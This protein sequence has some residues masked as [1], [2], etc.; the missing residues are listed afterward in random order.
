MTLEEA[1]T[2]TSDDDA[3]AAAAP[4]DVVVVAGSDHD[5]VTTV[6]KHVASSSL[7]KSIKTTASCRWKMFELILNS[8][9]PI[10]IVIQFISYTTLFLFAMVLISI[11]SKI[12]N[13]QEF[14]FFGYHGTLALGFAVIWIVI[15]GA[16]WSY[17]LPL[18]GGKLYFTVVGSF[19][20]CLSLL[21]HTVVSVISLLVSIKERDDNTYTL[22]YHQGERARTLMSVLIVCVGLYVLLLRS[23][24]GKLIEL[25]QILQFNGTRTKEEAIKQTD[26]NDIE[27]LL[28]ADEIHQLVIDTISALELEYTISADQVAVMDIRKGRYRNKDWSLLVHSLLKRVELCSSL[29]CGKTSCLTSSQYLLLVKELLA[30]IDH[31]IETGDEESGENTS[32]HAKTRNVPMSSFEIVTNIAG[33][34]MY[35][36]K[37]LLLTFVCAGATSTVVPLPTGGTD[38]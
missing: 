15:L 12:V 30:R 37:W 24:H 32:Y 38:W 1:T 25:R 2:K 8:V 17:L 26:D 5:A 21:L 35:V 13:P 29:Q 23:E 36:P 3:A 16:M 28:S 33:L 6:M 31:A 19:R 9:E 22:T 11:S 4:V 34:W 14:D 18:L 10:G 27:I 7:A 20:V